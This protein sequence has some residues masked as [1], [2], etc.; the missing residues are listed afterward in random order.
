[1]A[2]LFLSYSY[3]SGCRDTGDRSE[4]KAF[5]GSLF[6]ML[7]TIYIKLN[8]SYLRALFI[9]GLLNNF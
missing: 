7:E 8:I 1:M 5:S 4:W 3:L 9:K 6:L 2:S